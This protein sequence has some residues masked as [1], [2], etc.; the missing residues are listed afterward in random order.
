MACFL[1]YNDSVKFELVHAKPKE[2]F[3]SS[4]NTIVQNVVVGSNILCNSFNNYCN[5]NRD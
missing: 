5:D 1:N 3:L 4:I 2:D